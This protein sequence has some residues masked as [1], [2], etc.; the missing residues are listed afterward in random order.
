MSQRH[1]YNGKWSDFDYELEKAQTFTECQKKGQIV[2]LLRR[3]NKKQPNGI[4]GQ[5][6]HSIYCPY[7]RPFWTMETIAYKDESW[8]INIV[9]SE[10]AMRSVDYTELTT[11]WRFAS[12]Y[13]KSSKYT[14][15][16]GVGL[17]QEEQMKFFNGES[18]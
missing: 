4:L 7:S 9:D 1:K 18:D 12:D 6:S 5:Q 16:L 17:S 13:A 14:L 8:P 11:D 3:A 10:G 15:E 2:W